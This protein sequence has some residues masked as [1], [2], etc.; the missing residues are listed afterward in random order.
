MTFGD[1]VHVSDADSV[2]GSLCASR[3]SVGPTGAEH[4]IAEHL[5]AAEHRTA[6]HRT[7]FRIGMRSAVANGTDLISGGE[8][9]SGTRRS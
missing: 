4:L 3:P 7:L 5:V 1:W 9:P 2:G 6:E 8:L